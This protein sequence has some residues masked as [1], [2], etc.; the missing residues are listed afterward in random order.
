MDGLKF[1]ARLT[2]RLN[3]MTGDSDQV[4]IPGAK[5]IFI[6]LFFEQFIQPMFTLSVF[7]V[8]IDSKHCIETTREKYTI[9]TFGSIFLFWNM[10]FDFLPPLYT[11]FFTDWTENKKI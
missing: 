9:M 1:W 10:L 8:L 7:L 2:T 6:Y 5:I 11:V 4:K 3:A